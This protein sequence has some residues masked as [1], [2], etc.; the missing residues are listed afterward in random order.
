[1]G[2]T[3]GEGEKPLGKVLSG[4]L[5]SCRH[6]IS[7]SFCALKCHQIMNPPGL[8]I[9]FARILI[10]MIESIISEPWV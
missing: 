9:D 7:V 2:E 5:A 3:E 10:L 8:V 1:M 4:L 6:H